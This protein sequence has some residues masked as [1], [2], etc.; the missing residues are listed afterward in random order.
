MKLIEAFR[1]DHRQ[2]LEELDAVVDLSGG[3]RPDGRERLM[4]ARTMLIGH[5]ERE[6]RE[7]YPELRTAALADETLSR[8]L[9]ES[10][11]AM[12]TVST[13]AKRFFG[14]YQDSLERV[15]FAAHLAS[16]RDMLERRIEFEEEQLYPALARLLR[17]SQP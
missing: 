8:L 9:E 14:E 5:L 3:L 15:G 2:I 12:G 10:D 6:D 13:F 4:R 7:M 1:A 17:Q 11:R 16:M